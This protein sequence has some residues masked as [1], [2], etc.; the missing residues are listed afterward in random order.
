MK[1]K[2]P[3]KNKKT[4][5]KIKPKKLYGLEPLTYN[6]AAQQYVDIDYVSQ[7]NDSEKQW[8]STFNEEYYNNTLNKDWRKNLHYK[9][10]KKS[11]FDK[12]NARN[13][14][15]MNKRYRMDDE[16]N[17]I[18]D[19]NDT[20]YTSPESAM[21]EAIDKKEDIE[22]FVKKARRKGTDEKFTKK[23][24]DVVFGVED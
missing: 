15:I 4:K 18:M 5:A 2:K 14:D 13:R 17:Y 6:R 19:N 3:N 16:E 7:L 10:H 12:T 11:I 8:L 23:L 21:I 9:E 22:H 20:E 24:T 1:K